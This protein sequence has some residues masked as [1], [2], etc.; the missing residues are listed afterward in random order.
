MGDCEG[1]LEYLNSQPYSNGKTGVIGMCS[2]GRHAFMAACQIQGFGAAV[3]CWG[4]GVVMSEKALTPAQ[5][6][7]PIDLTEELTCPLL[8]LF[9]NDDKMPTPAEVDLH[10]EALKK[11]GK[12]Y[13]FH[14][15]DGAGHGF[16]Y[17]PTEMYRPR[18]A[19]DAWEKTFQFLG[20]HLAGS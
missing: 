18:Q 11:Y 20:K 13:E 8:G 17:Y 19:M 3:D 16:W 12:D 6:K 7:A 9:G 2:G 4:G 1:A 5:P 10:E 15:Y 14:R